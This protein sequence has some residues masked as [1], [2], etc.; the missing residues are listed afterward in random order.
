VKDASIGGLADALVVLERNPLGK[1]RWGYDYIT[2]VLKIDWLGVFLERLGQ[3][4]F[5]QPLQAAQAGFM[6]LI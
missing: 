4:F 1:R 3:R 6:N 2:G 5:K